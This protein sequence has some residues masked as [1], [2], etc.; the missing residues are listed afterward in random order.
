HITLV[1]AF[2]DHAGLS[3]DTAGKMRSWIRF[4]LRRQPA[5]G[6]NR[7]DMSKMLMEM[8]ATLLKHLPADF[9]GGRLIQNRFLTQLDGDSNLGIVVAQSS[10]GRAS[11][12]SLIAL[13]GEFLRLKLKELVYQKNDCPFNLFLVLSGTF[14]HVATPVFGGGYD[15]QPLGNFVR[16]HESTSAPAHAAGFRRRRNTLSEMNKA[17]KSEGGVGMFKS[18]GARSASKDSSAQDE[19]FPYR[20]FSAGSYFGEQELLLQGGDASVFRKTTARC[21]TRGGA[22]LVLHKEDLKRFC[23]MYPFYAST[24]RIHARRR[25]A[26]RLRSLH[27]LE[28]GRNHLGLAATT[29]QRFMG[30]KSFSGLKSREN[31]SEY[32][33]SEMSQFDIDL[34]I[35]NR[36]QALPQVPQRRHSVGSLPNVLALDVGVSHAFEARLARSEARYES[37]SASLASLSC[38]VTAMRGEMR[39]VLEALR[40]ERAPPR[41]PQAANCRMTKLASRQ[42]QHSSD[43][44]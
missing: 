21:E 17:E 29:I 18:E 39:C 26:H 11:L 14:A 13:S 6:L 22:L 16:H 23:N 28:L 8:P 1:N 35:Q 44:Q 15:S 40:G 38:D 27:L 9:F 10:T 42:M 12:T 20:L 2:V 19:L 30:R 4:T 5:N 24:W 3:E 36:S 25:E 33:P 37:V 41:A 7:D 43:K 34:L 31:D 32:C